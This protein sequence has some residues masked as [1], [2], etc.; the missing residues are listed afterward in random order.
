MLCNAVAL[1]MSDIA[2]LPHREN[3]ID[4]RQYDSTHGDEDV[5]DPLLTAHEL[6]RSY[7]KCAGDSLYS[8]GVLLRQDVPMVVSPAVLARAAAE[9]ASR[10]WYM[11]DPGDS[12]DARV[13]KMTL[14][15]EGAF[16]REGFLRPDARP[17]ERDLFDRL[18]RWTKR[19]PKAALNL[20]NIE[21]FIT[22]MIGDVG[23]AE[24][25]WLSGYV[26]ATATTVSYSYIKAA[27]GDPQ[28]EL[29][30]WRQ[31]LFASGLG[32]MAAD[33][34]SKLKQGGAEAVE[35]LKL[36]HGHYGQQYDMVIA[37]TSE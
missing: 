10:S 19:R 35:N 18:G 33:R 11:T 14:L 26:H 37:P 3:Q 8:I 20:P 29:D 9:H 12:P 5:P 31:A 24:Y 13:A 7:L 32:V 22:S 2:E 15:L 27:S 16:K 6:T 23:K 21:R 30:S 36:L 17:E 28:R 4:I 1:T 34:M 25:D